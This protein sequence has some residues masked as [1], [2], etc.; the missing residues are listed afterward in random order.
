MSALRIPSVLSLPRL[1]PEAWIAPGAVVLG[2]VRVARGASVWYGCVL[3]S[4]L[5]EAWIEIGEDANIQDGTIVHVDIDKPCRVGARVTVGHRA[6]LH[7][8]TIEDDVLIGMG[9]VVLSGAVV[10]RGSIVAAGALVGEG[11]V[12]P[13]GSVAAGL[14]ARVRREIMDADRVRM[15]H[16]WRMYAALRDLH[17]GMTR[18]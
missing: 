15:E 2:D 7:G 5:E 4:D 12:I 3:R 9:A 10:G 16:G 13:P 1:D 6:V 18:R 17:R 8:A 11:V 14:P